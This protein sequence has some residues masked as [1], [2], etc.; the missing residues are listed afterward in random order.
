MRNGD[1]LLL[2]QI[3]HSTGRSYWLLPGGRKE[4]GETEQQCVQREM[5]EEV[6]LH[7]RVDEL[8][9]DEPVV[10]ENIDRRKTYLCSIVAGEPQP[11]YEPEEA[12]ADKYSFT[13]VQWVDLGRPVSWAADVVADQGSLLQQI[14]A[15]LGCGPGRIDL[16]GAS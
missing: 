7:V 10:S 4:S 11:G 13:G 5:L 9:L 8:L 12:Y 6:G 1:I 15:A 3:E 14:R 16:S 2:Q